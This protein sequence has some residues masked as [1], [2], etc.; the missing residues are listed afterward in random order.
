MTALPEF[1]LV[2]LEK[3]K[4][5]EEIDEENVV[6]I[7]GRLENSKVFDDP[8]WVARGSF[9]I[10]NGHH[11]VEALRRMGA[12]RVPAWLL[13]Y[14][15]DLVSVEPW[16][17]GLPITKAE[18]VE[19]GLSGNPFPPKTTRHHLKVELPSRPTPL[20]VLVAPPGPPAHRTAAKRSPRSRSRASGPG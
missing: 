7:V 1:E 3:L 5:H 9:V 6:E 18:V 10:L 14:E 17:P 8:I 2:P 4:A 12:R 13:D 16:R 20:S 11:R 19:R 15:S